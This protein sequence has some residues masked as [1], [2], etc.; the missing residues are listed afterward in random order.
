MDQEFRTS[1]LVSA[2]FTV[3]W[4]EI[5]GDSAVVSV[6][7]V[8][9]SGLCRSYGASLL[10]VQS[11]YWRQA[12]GLPMAGRRVVPRVMARRFWCDAV[13]SGRCIFAE[14]SGDD[15]LAPMSRRTGRLKM[16]VHHLGVALGGRPAARFA[17]RLMV[18]ASNDTLLRV[19]RRRA[20][21][22]AETLR[23]RHR[24]LRLAAQSSLWHNCLRP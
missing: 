23:D 22:P 1:R 14:R 18:S 19:V 8:A 20:R 4:S 13:L 2:G 12:A 3:E 17:D 6:R 10:R 7:A 9:V 24:R 15:V 21:L 5:N 16:T 11:R